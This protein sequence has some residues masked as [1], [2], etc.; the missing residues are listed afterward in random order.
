MPPKKKKPTKKPRAKKSVGSGLDGILEKL[1]S[2]AAFVTAAAPIAA[3]ALTAVDGLRRRFRPAPPPPPDAVA[4]GIGAV[5]EGTKDAHARI[6]ALQAENDD[7]RASLRL[8]GVPVPDAVRGPGR[9]PDAVDGPPE[10]QEPPRG[11][12]EATH[13]TVEA[14]P[15]LRQTPQS[16]IPPGETVWKRHDEAAAARGEPVPLA[17]VQ[18]APGEFGDPTKVVALARRSKKK[19]R[20]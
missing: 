16:A 3:T 12:Q 17:P 13:S 9:A 18:S 14:A 6:D 4:Q 2:V 15:E 10:P 5:L 1:D 7:L 11:P 19:R 8:N 20:G